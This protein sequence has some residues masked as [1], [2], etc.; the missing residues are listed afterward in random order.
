M[1]MP[2][3]INLPEKGK[4]YG[5]PCFSSRPVKDI[6]LEYSSCC[7]AGYYQGFELVRHQ[8]LDDRPQQCIDDNGE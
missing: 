7:S 1:R 8:S 5:C 2:K 6:F 4:C 3:E